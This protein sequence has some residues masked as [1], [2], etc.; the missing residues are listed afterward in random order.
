MACEPKWLMACEGL[1]WEGQAPLLPHVCQSAMGARC[2]VIHS[3]TAFCWMCLS[4]LCVWGHRAPARAR[5]ES[6]LR[7][8]CMSDFFLI[9]VRACYPRFLSPSSHRMGPYGF[10]S[11]VFCTVRTCHRPSELVTGAQARHGNESNGIAG[12]VCLHRD[13]CVTTSLHVPGPYHT[14]I[15]K[16]T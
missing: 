12:A 5:F 7:S 4:F 6:G 10:M 8:L 16:E 1:A 14:T 13:Y 9:S 3:F 15:F 2:G 11:I